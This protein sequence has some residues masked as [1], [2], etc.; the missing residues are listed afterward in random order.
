VYYQ[1]YDQV[2]GQVRGQV[3]G[4]VRDQKMQYYSPYIGLAWDANWVSFGEFFKEI[5]ILKNSDFEQYAEILESGIFMSIQLDNCAIVCERPKI[6]HRNEAHALHYDQGAAISWNDGY[7]IY[8]LH[9][10]RFEKNLYWKVVNQEI[11]ITDMLKNIPNAD[12]RSVALVMTKPDELLKHMNAELVSTGLK[13]TRAKQPTKLY[14]VPNFMETG[15][16]E[17]C[18]TMACPSTDRP[19]LE[20]VQPE[21]GKKHDADL[22]QATAFGISKKQYMAIAPGDEA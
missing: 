3:S 18:M 7:E 16:T 8:A 11:T 5:G 21:I 20:W 4:Q 14:K 6:I 9:G 22:A 2:R 12:Q 15:D 13:P 10:V 19:F 17:Y 1:V